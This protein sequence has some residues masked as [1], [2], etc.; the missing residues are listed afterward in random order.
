MERIGL[1]GGMGIHAV[2]HAGVFVVH[3]HLRQNQK[4]ALSLPERPSK[5]PE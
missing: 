2:P 1:V 5:Q 3:V 4:V